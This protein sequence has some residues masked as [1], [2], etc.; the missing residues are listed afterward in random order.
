[1]CVMDK[2]S[3]MCRCGM[4]KQND[5]VSVWRF[6][7]WA[8]LRTH[9]PASSTHHSDRR[10]AGAAFVAEGASSCKTD[11]KEAKQGEQDLE[12]ERG[13]HPLPDGCLPLSGSAHRPG[14][15][16]GKRAES[17]KKGR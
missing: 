15:Y 12:V 2:T 4:R 6:R 7:Q 10:V 8:E 14:L 1:M 11:S 3:F 9:L 17:E 13:C 16:R 5:R